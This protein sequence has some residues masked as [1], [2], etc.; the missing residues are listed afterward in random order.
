MVT[1]REDGRQ[2]VAEVGSVCAGFGCQ[3]LET[4]RHHPQTIA[5]DVL[6]TC[7]RKTGS[8]SAYTNTPKST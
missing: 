2:R 8:E 4:D 3:Q 7:D 1:I 6:L 5:N